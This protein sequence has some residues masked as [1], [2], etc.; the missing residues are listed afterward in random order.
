MIKPKKYARFVLGYLAV[1]HLFIAAAAWRMNGI[2]NERVYGSDDFELT[3]FVA[4]GYMFVAIGTLLSAAII[5]LA[6]KML[7]G[8][9]KHRA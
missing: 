4:R 5:L 7:K 6:L 3:Q 1:V 2:Y 9:G 8:T